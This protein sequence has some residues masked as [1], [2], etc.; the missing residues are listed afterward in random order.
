MGIDRV[1]GV[2]WRRWQLWGMKWNR[3]VLWRRSNPMASWN[4]IVWGWG[5]RFTLS[6]EDPLMR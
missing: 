4:F 5:E 3:R 1:L 2:N 6:R